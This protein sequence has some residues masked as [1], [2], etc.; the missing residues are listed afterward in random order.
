MLTTIKKV[1]PKPVKKILIDIKIRNYD[2]WQKKRLS[3][4]MQSKHTDLLQQIKG[5]ERIKVVFLVIHKSVW[6]V[7]SVFQKMLMDPLFDPEV[8]VCPYIIYG[9][10]RMLEDLEQTY[11]YF[12]RKGYPAKKSL[13]NDGSWVKLE[14]VKPDIVFFTNPHDLTR[15]EYYEEAYLNYLSGYAGYGI[16]VSKYR[17]CQDQYNQEFHN[18]VWQIFLQHKVG[19][20]LSKEYAANKGA[21]TYL[22][23]DTL[24]E[25]MLSS[26]NQ[27]VAWKKQDEKK[28]KIIWAPHHTITTD[29][30]KMLPYSTFLQYAESM[31]GIANEL[32]STV[33]FAFKPHPILRSKLYQHP[34]WGKE[35][36]DRYYDFWQNSSNTQIDEGEYIALFN[37]SDAMI[38]DSAAFTAEYLF[39]NKPVMHLGKQ[40][41]ERFF[42]DFALEAYHCHYKAKSKTDIL[43][44]IETHIS[45]DLM[46]DTREQ[47]IKKHSYV[48]GDIEQPSALIIKNIKNKLGRES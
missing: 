19:M 27:Q 28:L 24:I 21:N 13:N 35:E 11:D 42:N 15:K 34:Q 37:Q 16:A 26:T 25:Q 38:H 32:K 44:F 9:E 31:M 14:D 2:Q 48:V 23:G 45:N 47:F 8:L 5:K 22:V 40:G 10:E 17:N 39:L 18:A 43:Q 46:A 7:D 36:T 20:S 41:V 30:I 33:Q 6:K 4:R 3:K 12:L 1:L 29:D